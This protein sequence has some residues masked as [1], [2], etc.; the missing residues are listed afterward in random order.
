MYRYH[1]S[2]EDTVIFEQ[3]K[4]LLSEDEYKELGEKFEQEEI[5]KIGKNPLS[6]RQIFLRKTKTVSKLDGLKIL[7]I[8]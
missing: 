7:G 2:R 1:E 8:N 6:N 5:E 3:I 4:K